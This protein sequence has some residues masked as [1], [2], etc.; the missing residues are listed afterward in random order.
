M[1]KSLRPLFRLIFN[2]EGVQFTP[3]SILQTHALNREH[4]RPSL[5]RIDRR[6]PL[7]DR[8]G[9]CRGRPLA[10]VHRQDS[11]GPDRAD[12][13]LWTDARRSRQ[14]AAPVVDSRA[15]TC[16][17]GRRRPLST[18]PEPWRGGR[19]QLHRSPLTPLAAHRGFRRDPLDAGPARSSVA[20]CDALRFPL[21]EAFR[22]AATRLLMR[23]LR[24]I[25]RLKYEAGLS[26]GF[27]RRQNED[28]R[29]QPPE[30]RRCLQGV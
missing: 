23:K 20:S 17:R 14:T 12:A 19:P 22:M 1:C 30:R 16:F 4:R 13:L 27:T 18:C 5:R 21:L 9:R 29:T 26:R 8:G 15:R 7:P 6:T 24:D 10:R 3:L 11:R 28:P 2:A 25:L